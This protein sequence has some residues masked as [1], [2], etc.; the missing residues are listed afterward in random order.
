M[1]TR[2]PLAIS[3]Q[4]GEGTRY[5]WSYP[6]PPLTTSG[7]LRG[8]FPRNSTHSFPAGPSMSRP[9]AS[10]APAEIPRNISVI[11]RA[12]RSVVCMPS[13]F[14]TSG[15]FA[16]T[17]AKRTA[18]AQR[19]GV[20]SGSSGDPELC[21]LPEDLVVEPQD[22]K[23]QEPHRVV[24]AERSLRVDVDVELF[25][26]RPDVPHPDP[27]RPGRVK[28][29]EAGIAELRPARI[30]DQR[31][32]LPQLGPEQDRRVAERHRKADLDARANGT[33]HP[34]AHVEACVEDAALAGE[35]AEPPGV[36]HGSVRA[37]EQDDLAAH[38]PGRVQD[39]KSVV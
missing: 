20:R 22:R 30:E 35:R 10:A 26:E 2:R 7:G 6:G 34:L 24:A 23:S 12:V 5:P 9:G 39:R 19:S 38:A 1:T 31:P 13:P 32:L 25:L 33:R 18:S 29:V 4:T 28:T 14:V 27:V 37:A 15:T 16:R 21:R 3:S 11:A 36:T 17:T 8:A